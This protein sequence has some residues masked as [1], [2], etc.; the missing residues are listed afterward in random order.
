M[1]T[2]MSW[3][4]QATALTI[5]VSWRCLSVSERQRRQRCLEY[6]CSR[7]NENAGLRREASTVISAEPRSATRVSAS[8]EPSPNSSPNS[9]RLVG[10]RQSETAFAV[11]SPEP[12]GSTSLLAVGVCQELTTNRPPDQNDRTIHTRSYCLWN[13]AC[14]CLLQHSLTRS[15]QNDYIVV[16]FFHQ[17]NQTFRN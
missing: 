4:P 16:F 7:G 13:I 12:H 17:V 11:S 5:K 1:V 9:E 2:V 14:N 6:L 8:S 3:V 10:V 15:T